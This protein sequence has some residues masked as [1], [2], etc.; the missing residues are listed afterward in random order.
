MKSV[1]V[2]CGSSYGSNPVYTHAASETGTLIAK[3]GLTL[4]YGGAKVGLMG[5]V[6]DAALAAGGEVIGVLPTSLQEKELAHDG[7]SELHIVGSMHER[8]AQMA[9]LSDAFLTLPGGAGTMEEL[10]EVWTW[11]QLGLHNKPCGFLNTQ[12]FY[13]KL[14]GFLDFQTQEGFMKPVMRDMVQA[15]ANPA[16]LLEMFRAYQPPATPKWIEAEET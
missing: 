6:A 8:K 12:G 5:T 13:D 4:V 7:L 15:A 10:F 2:F 9:E 3:Q 14:L 16:D 1:C 11:G